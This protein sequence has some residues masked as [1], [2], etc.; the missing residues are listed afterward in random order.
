M[1]ILAL[2]TSSAS[3]SIAVL[4]GQK[5]LAEV[6][7]G[8]VGK[9]SDWLMPSIDSLLKDLNISINEIDIFAVDIGPGSFTGLRIGIS[10]IKGLAWPLGKKIVGVSTLEALALNLRA[11]GVTVCPILD[12][13]K[14]EVYTALYRY[15]LDK[16]ETVMGDSA[17]KPEAIIEEVNRL[18]APVIFLG[19]G[20][21]AYLERIKTEV[22]KVLIAP[23]LLWHLRASNI[24]LRAL[25]RLDTA[26]DASEL[27]PV[28]LRKSEAE[29]KAVAEHKTR[30]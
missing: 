9:H 18:E 28:Y 21:K 23:E 17:V 30:P 22:K 3:G 27:T 24:G 13:R 5:L 4:S 16:I 8:N 12:A 2:D 6:T 7:I 19:D 25:E 1:K 26:K 14:N 10:T 29:L 20:L 15:D 11:S